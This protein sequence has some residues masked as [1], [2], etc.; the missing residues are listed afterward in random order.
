MPK[1]IFFLS[2][3]GSSKSDRPN[4]QLGNHLLP[5]FFPV[6]FQRRKIA[7]PAVNRNQLI[8]VERKHGKLLPRRASVRHKHSS[9]YLRGNNS[10]RQVRSRGTT[11]RS[12]TPPAV[13]L[14]KFTILDPRFPLCVTYYGH[15]GRASLAQPR[16]NMRCFDGNEHIGRHF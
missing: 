6:S 9:T 1:F 8:N 5:H 11:T 7:G 12:G 14:W 2:P 3:E 10:R 4:Y 15:Y 16:L 13:A